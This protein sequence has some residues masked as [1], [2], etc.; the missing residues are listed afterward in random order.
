[1]NC[2]GTRAAGDGG[3]TMC[4]MRGLVTVIC[5]PGL[6]PGNQTRVAAHRFEPCGAACQRLEYEGGGAAQQGAAGV[7]G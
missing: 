6:L 2:G 4:K 3:W 1:M 5:V 7:A